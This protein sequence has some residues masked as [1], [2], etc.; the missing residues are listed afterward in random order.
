MDKQD[1]T[2]LR[3]TAQFTLLGARH[4]TGGGFYGVVSP[5][6]G[7]LMVGKIVSAVLMSGDISGMGGSVKSSCRAGAR[8]RN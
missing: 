8:E 4:Q 2:G 7:K 6:G 5:K 1:L 3:E